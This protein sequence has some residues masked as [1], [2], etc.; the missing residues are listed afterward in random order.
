MSAPI[1]Y[2]NDSEEE[3]LGALIYKSS[4]TAKK[5]LGLGSSTSASESGGASNTKKRAGPRTSADDCPARN[6]GCKLIHERSFHY[7]LRSGSSKCTGESVLQQTQSQASEFKWASSDSESGNEDD[8]SDEEYPAEPEPSSPITSH[9]TSKRYNLRRAS[10]RHARNEA[11]GPEPER[12]S[13]AAS[14]APPSLSS[15]YCAVINEDGKSAEEKM[16]GTY[17]DRKGRDFVIERCAGKKYK[18]Y[19]KPEDANN[20][21]SRAI[22][23][24][25]HP[26]CTNVSIKGGVCAKHGAKKRCCKFEG[27]TNQRQT[28]QLCYRHGA[29]RKIL[30]CK[31]EGCQSHAQKGGVCFK[32]S[33]SGYRKCKV[34]GCHKKIRTGGTCRGHAPST[35]KPKLCKN[36][37]CTN[38]AKMR[39]EC[40]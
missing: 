34:E 26:G 30:F 1:N 18:R 15:T 29:P 21:K 31:H 32:H 16:E 28:K 38:K 7:S 36:E 19:C 23:L 27:C 20:N 3:E 25:K 11:T 9:S 5:F 17:T 14:T 13:S 12:I 4:Q 40:T 33:P 37:G 6:E 22:L 2:L 24:C 8:S 35:L 10:N 39:V